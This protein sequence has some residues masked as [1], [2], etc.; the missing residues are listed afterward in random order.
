[1]CAP[2][3]AAVV[4]MGQAVAGFAG[5]VMTYQS[6]KAAWNQNVEN[7]RGSAVDQQKGL[8]TRLLQEGAKTAQ[9]KHLSYLEEAKRSSEARVSAAS[10]GVGAGASVDAIVGEITAR[11]ALNRTNAETN[12]QWTV[13][14]ITNRLKATETQA[15]GRI[16]SM[17]E[18]VA[19]NPASLALNVAAAGMA[20]YQGT[21]QGRA[22]AAQF[23]L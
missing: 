16:A 20:P 3:L 22:V 23:N 21:A 6:Q 4:G 9:E 15:E 11:S 1:M 14:D 5:Q 18:P 12:Y 7:A 10:A 8:Q 17:P 19:P 2:A 13:S